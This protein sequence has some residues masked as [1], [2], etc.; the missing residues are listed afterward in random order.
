MFMVIISSFSFSVSLLCWIFKTIW[1][2]VTNL[3]RIRTKLGLQ[4]LFLFGWYGHKTRH[5]IRWTEAN[6]L[7]SKKKKLK[8]LDWENFCIL[9]VLIGVPDKRKNNQMKGQSKRIL[10]YIN[11]S[12]GI[13]QAN[14]WMVASISHHQ[15]SC[16]LLVQA[17][18][19]NRL[20]ILFS[21]LS[22]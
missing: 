2:E 8:K 19:N 14:A 5:I 15:G 17:Y 6:S 4:V 10:V 12:H 18:S 3:Q 1:S 22:L 9:D 7:L 16:Q 13:S 20:A 21:C 11:H